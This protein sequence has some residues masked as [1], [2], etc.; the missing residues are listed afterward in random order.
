MKPS[1]FTSRLWLSYFN[2]VFGSLGIGYTMTLLNQLD[3][4][5]N[6]WFLYLEVQNSSTTY[7]NVCYNASYLAASGEFD[8]FT[9]QWS[10]ISSMAL[11]GGVLGA[12]SQPL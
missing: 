10:V 12:F 7:A 3:N 6:C 11:F 8:R 5:V 1:Q 2:I 9:F 4:L